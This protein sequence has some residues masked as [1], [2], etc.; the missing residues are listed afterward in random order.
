MSYLQKRLP[1]L[2]S[3]YGIAQ[4]FSQPVAGSY[5]R[6]ATYRRLST[7]LAE[8]R[9]GSAHRA[10]FS[11]LE[12]SPSAL[13]IRNALT[14]SH[15]TLRGSP[16]RQLHSSSRLQQQ[17][18]KKPATPDDQDI[19]KDSEKKPEAERSGDEEAKAKQEG[20]EGADEST[21]DGEQKKKEDAP[22]PPKHGDKTPWQV[23]TETLQSEFKASKEWNESTKALQSG[24]DEFTQN[25]NVQRARSAKDAV[26]STTSAAFKKT[27]VALGSGA[28]WT[29]DTSVVKGLRK[30]T[31]ATASAI[32][33]ATRPV[34]E[35]EA[36]K[37]VKNVIDDG[38]SSRYGGW[39][40]KE[41]RRKKRELRE[42]ND[43]QRTGGRKLEPM[44][45]DPE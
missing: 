10:A 7:V 24:M 29:W 22:P 14:P 28:A 4:S 39:A 2:Q 40:E 12:A 31:N 16:L 41:E 25:P 21:K 23:F 38:S 6:S 9:Q 34:R 8:S 19:K 37:S 33:K 45:E 32:E 30:G 11:I 27:G 1:R 13:P 5:G 42:L 26:S 18:Q 3:A 36:Y 17:E 20:S 15:I 43:L 44:V 35:T